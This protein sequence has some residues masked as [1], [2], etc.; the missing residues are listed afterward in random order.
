[1]NHYLI[2]IDLPEQMDDDFIA[3]IPDQ[4]LHINRLMQEGI[5][6]SYSLASDRSKLWT[7]VI[8]DNEE[9]V[10]HILNTFPLISYFIYSIHELAF[11]NTA[12]YTMPPISLN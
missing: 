11:H 2:D 6:T 12:Q 9:E 8:A 7:T 5:I 1:M 10:G 4:R 3:M